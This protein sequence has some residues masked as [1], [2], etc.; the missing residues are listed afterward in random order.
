MSITAKLPFTHS[1]P[2]KRGRAELTT[3]VMSIILLLALFGGLAT[4]HV[5]RGEA[6]PPRFE[7]T[8]AWSDA[9]RHGD[10]W[11][12]PVDVTNAG[13][14]TADT[15]TVSLERP[16]PGEQPETADLEFVFV[17]GGETVRGVAVFDE[18]PTPETVD[19]GSISYTEP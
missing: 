15:V 14:L 11:Y 2:P 12:L 10:E 19:T 3:L 16:V 8:P 4:L 13:D 1:P 9:S 6:S 17:A 18:E 5:V 7:I